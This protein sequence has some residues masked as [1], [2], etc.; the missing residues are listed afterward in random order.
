MI[1][2]QYAKMLEVTH[3]IGNMTSLYEPSCPSA[4]WLVDLQTVVL[5]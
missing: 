2:W 4:G 1:F 3:I 5:T